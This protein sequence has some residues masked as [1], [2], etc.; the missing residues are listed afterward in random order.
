MGCI[1]FAYKQMNWFAAKAFCQTLT[2]GSHLIEVKTEALQN[3]IVQ[4]KKSSPVTTDW[5][6]WLGA[7]DLAKARSKDIIVCS[8]KIEDSFLATAHFQEGEWRWET[9]GSLFNYTGN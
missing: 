3:F 6:Y 9:D 8:R 2:E 5:N 7:T 1:Y 4:W